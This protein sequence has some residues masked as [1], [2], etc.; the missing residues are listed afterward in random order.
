MFVVEGLCKMIAGKV[1]RQ[2]RCQDIRRSDRLARHLVDIDVNLVDI[3]VN[4]VDI[5]VN[6][7]DIDVNLVDIDVNLVDI[8]VNLVR[9]LKMDTT[10]QW[11]LMSSRLDSSL[12]CNL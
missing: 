8:D 1:V 5:D 2:P 7:V 12:R 4:L 10:L 9:H 6:L 3:D 11:T